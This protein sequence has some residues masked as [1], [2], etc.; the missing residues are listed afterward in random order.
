L[1][2]ISDLLSR[3]KTIEQGRLLAS[4]FAKRVAVDKVSDEK[5][6]AAEFDILKANAVGYQRRENLGVYGKSQLVNSL[7]WSLIAGGYPEGFAKEIG[8]QLAVTLAASR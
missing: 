1:G 4:Q 5:R 6:V 8:G 7:Q 2:L 3:K